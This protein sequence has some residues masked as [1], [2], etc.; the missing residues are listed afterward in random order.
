MCGIAGFKQGPDT[1]DPDALIRRML[2]HMERRGP[3]GEGVACYA[4]PT[5]RWFFGHR[6]LA[7]IDIEGGYQP[8]ADEGGRIAVVFNGEI[9]NFQSLQTELVELGHRFRTRSDT[10]VLIEG[11]KAWGMPGLV[12]RLQGMFAFAV[13]DMDRDVLFLARDPYG[14]KPLYY[15]QLPAGGI[16]FASSLRSLRELPGADVE[17]DREALR[18]GLALRHI[19]APYTAFKRIRKLAA[20]CFARVAGRDFHE[21]QYASD[22]AVVEQGDLSEQEMIELVHKQLRTCVTDC[23]VSDVPVALMLSSGLDS[24]LVAAMLAESGRTADVPAVTVGFR[25]RS[26]DES[27]EAEWLARK[28]GLQHVKVMVEERNVDDAV[29]LAFDVHDEPFADPSLVPSLVLAEAVRRAAKVALGG[30]G[31]DELFGG[32]PTFPAIRYYRSL[33]SLPV[34]RLVQMAALLLPASHARYARRHKVQRF[35]RALGLPPEQAFVA[36]LMTADDDLI[37]RVGGEDAGAPLARLFALV[38]DV[39]DPD[40]TR[41]MSRQY[42]RLFLS[43]VLNKVD[44]ASMNYGLEVR[45]PFLQPDMVGLA[46]SLPAVARVKGSQTKYILRRLAKQLGLVEHSRIA[47]RGFNVPLSQWIR[48]QL[49]PRVEPYLTRRALDD[50]GFLHTDTVLRRWQEHRSGR[51]NHFD[52]L[53]AIIMTQRFLLGGG[54]S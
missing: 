4:C 19:P 54:R 30:D 32:Y 51:E 39:R 1:A 22:A 8:M 9:Y 5:G 10:E 41:L 15:M 29:S 16:A 2:K 36:W 17:I 6:R 33:R 48:G 13:L 31:G 26:Y 34:K 43:G 27:P 40:P 52:L 37:A 14:Q 28:L 20:G 47:K 46:L 12:R 23:L 35:A 18:L 49:R 25:E 38:A 3:D 11:Y 7:I 42:L 53:W 24:S 45:A 50:A 21:E 44:T